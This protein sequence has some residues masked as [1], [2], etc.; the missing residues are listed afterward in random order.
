MVAEGVEAAPP[1]V[2][3][4]AARGSGQAVHSETFIRDGYRHRSIASVHALALAAAS[5]CV[6][7]LAMWAAL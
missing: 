7:T 3:A 5:A 1:R 2:F 6:T 4:R